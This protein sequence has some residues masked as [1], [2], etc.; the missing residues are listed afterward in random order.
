MQTE[1]S[2]FKADSEVEATMRRA[3][4]KVE[5]VLLHFTEIPGS[6]GNDKHIKYL[7]LLDCSV[8][9]LAFACRKRS[10]TLRFM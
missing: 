1:V 3:I 8:F 5:S 10:F 6:Y 7:S 4:L 9:N 2:K